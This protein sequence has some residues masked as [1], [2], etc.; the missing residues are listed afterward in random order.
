MTKINRSWTIFETNTFASGKVFVKIN[1]L[2]FRLSIGQLTPLSQ[3][4]FRHA[5]EQRATWTGRGCRNEQFMC[6]MGIEKTQLTFHY[7]FHNTVWSH[8]KSSIPNPS[9]YLMQILWKLTNVSSF[10]SKKTKEQLRRLH[11]HISA[12]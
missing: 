12:T 11:N 7:H 5:L 8:A 4:V 2:S 6:A 9:V 10:Y 1:C 3:H